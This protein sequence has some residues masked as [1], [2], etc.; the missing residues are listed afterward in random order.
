M[1]SAGY[2]GK[3]QPAGACLRKIRPPGR[4]GCRGGIFYLKFTVMQL[5]AFLA[6]IM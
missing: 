5:L 4:T 3:L 1:R 6:E 2:E